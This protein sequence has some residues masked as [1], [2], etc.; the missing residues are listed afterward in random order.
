MN[1]KRHGRALQHFQMYVWLYGYQIEELKGHVFDDVSR[2][3]NNWQTFN[4]ISIYT[5]SSG[6]Y[7]TQKLLFACS[8][9]G[10]LTPVSLSLFFSL[11]YAFV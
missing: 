8:V 5:Y 10:N 9:K 1:N 11:L 7:L 4:N 2:S 3:F 6:M